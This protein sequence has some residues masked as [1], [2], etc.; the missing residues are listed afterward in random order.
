MKYK[1][2]RDIPKACRE[3][4]TLSPSEI[5]GWIREHRTRR[6]PITKKREQENRSP[7]SVSMW[8][9]DHPDVYQELKNE[10]GTEEIPKEAITEA[11]FQNG[12][13]QEIPCVKQWI[14]DLTNNGAKES[15]IKRFVS[16]LRRICKG[17]VRG[18]KKNLEYIE[19]WG[20]KHPKNLT[21]EDG[22]RFVYEMTKRGYATR[23]VRLTL[24]NFLLSKGIVVRPTD[25]S[26]KEEDAG[27]YADLYVSKKKI[28]EILEWIKPLNPVAYQASLFSYKTA[29]RSTATL[30]ADASF[31][32]WDTHMVTV[33]EKASKGKKK[34]RI[35]KKIP[36]E[37]W[38]E[39]PREGKLFP[40]EV[41]DLNNILRS[42][43]KEVIPET[44]KRIHNP[45][46]FWRH[47][48]AQHMLRAT[49]MNYGL[50]A[51]LGGW[52]VGALEK[53]YGKMD[54]E[55]A[56]SLGKNALESL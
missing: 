10:I 30:N 50:V 32:N 8:F 43:Y 38:D 16:Q 7:Q 44:E 15:S 49:E 11:I 17:I 21:L 27:K 33:F 54:M 37:L 31:V 5:V 24:R 56:L 39:L 23:N 2:S 36:K 6:N 1:P 18:R 28:Y 4:K 55:T 40:I 9:R 45:F 47:M 29:T 42:A 26:G 13:F 14:V 35:P 22:K 3:L 48:F 41:Q 51:K 46:H 20:L 34:R 53:Y 19:E 52:T 12:F 25:I